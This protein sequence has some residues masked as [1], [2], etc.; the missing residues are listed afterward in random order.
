[1]HDPQIA[2][3]SSLTSAE[4]VQTPAH[5]STTLNHF[6]EKLFKLAGLMKTA[7]GQ[8][9]AEQRHQYMVAF[10]EQFLAEYELPVSQ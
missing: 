9:L 3:R 1:M 5:K 2:A 4:Y 7:T 6:D 8:R 10:K